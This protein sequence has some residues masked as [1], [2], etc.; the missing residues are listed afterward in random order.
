VE[1]QFIRVAVFMAAVGAIFFLAGV[2]AARW[3][4]RR[5]RRVSQPLSWKAKAILVF[6][7]I[8]LICIPYGFLVEPFWPEVTH[9][10]IKSAKLTKGTRGIRIVHISDVHSDAKPRLETKLPGIIA[11]QKPDLIVFTGDSVNHRDNAP[12]FR[13]LMR[14]LAA[15]APTYAV[16]GNWDVAGSS[17]LLFGGTGAT[18]LQ[19]IA[20]RVTVRENTIVISGDSTDS[21]ETVASAFSLVPASDFRIYLHHFPDRI[22]EVARENVDLY[23]A[24]HTHGGQVA[25]PFYG[26]LI[27]FSKYDKQFEHGLYHVQNTWLYVN[28]GI[29]M[30]GSRAPRVRFCARPEVTVIDLQPE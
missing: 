30:E 15:I 22:Y 14:Q 25:L 7:A 21:M 27:T 2:I 29:G 18:E 13:E 28:R 16:R 20:Q 24:G 26:A 6:A 1:I 4:W 12:I 3:I 17:S 9:V 10:T 19:G 11:A 23:L 5:L 8:G